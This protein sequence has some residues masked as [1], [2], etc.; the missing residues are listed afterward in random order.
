VPELLRRKGRGKTPSAPAPDDEK[1]Q[2]HKEM[3]K[4]RRGERGKGCAQRVDD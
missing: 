2:Q 3:R 1:E 4:K